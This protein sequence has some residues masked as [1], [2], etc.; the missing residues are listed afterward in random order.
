MGSSVVP[1]ASEEVQFGGAGFDSAFGEEE[2]NHRR[3]GDFGVKI[4]AEPFGEPAYARL[5]TTGRYMIGIP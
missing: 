3:G 5:V 4:P 1:G 2:G